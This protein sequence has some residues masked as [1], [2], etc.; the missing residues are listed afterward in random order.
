MRTIRWVLILGLVPCV[1]F[2]SCNWK[3]GTSSQLRNDTA[4]CAPISEVN[5]E[6]MIEKAFQMLFEEALQGFFDDFFDE[7]SERFITAVEECADKCKLSPLES[8]LLFCLLFNQKDDR[9][10]DMPNLSELPLPDDDVGAI[11]LDVHFMQSPSSEPLS[12]S[13]QSEP[14][15]DALTLKVTKSH[16]LGHED[17][18]A[19]H[20]AVVSLHALCKLGE[21]IETHTF[22]VDMDKIV[23]ASED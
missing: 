14:I 20:V 18:E 13:F 6:A 10:P 9:F 4:C 23:L 21:T 8:S 7:L 2:L 16:L 17:Q 1:L 15:F 5:A 3:S 11:I 19:T 12:Y 22:T